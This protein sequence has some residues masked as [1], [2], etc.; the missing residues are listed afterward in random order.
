MV[1]SRDRHLKVQEHSPRQA[2]GPSVCV[3]ALL[4]TVRGSTVHP[5]CCLTDW[6]GPLNLSPLLLD[7][8][9][10]YELPGSQVFRLTLKAIIGFLGSQPIIIIILPSAPLLNILNTFLPETLFFC[11]NLRTPNKWIHEWMDTCAEIKANSCLQFPDN[12][13]VVV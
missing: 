3:G 5:V 6:A 12:F 1:L 9:F 10:S 2:R 4:S 13:N 8:N 11:K 7:G